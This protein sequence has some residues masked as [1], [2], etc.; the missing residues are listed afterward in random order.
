MLSQIC[1]KNLNV[2]S[3]CNI[4]LVYENNFYILLTKTTGSSE[5][6]VNKIS[7]WVILEFSFS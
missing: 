7:K 4:N 2:S 3:K 6:L 5:V 1:S